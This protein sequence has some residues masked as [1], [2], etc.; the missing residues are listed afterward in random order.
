MSHLSIFQFWYFTQ[1]FVLLELA[2]L[3]TLIDLC[4][5]MRLFLRF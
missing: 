5:E 2:C 4:C 3:A 1:I